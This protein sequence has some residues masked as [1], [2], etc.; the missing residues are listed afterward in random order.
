MAGGMKRNQNPHL[1]ARAAHEHSEGANL[2]LLFAAEAGQT[3][4]HQGTFTEPE[5][6]QTMV[7]RPQEVTCYRATKR[8]KFYSW[9]SQ[10]KMGHVTRFGKA[11]ASN[12][13]A[14]TCLAALETQRADSKHLTD[15][16]LLP[17]NPCLSIYWS[18]PE[19]ISWVM[20]LEAHPVCSL[21]SMLGGLMASKN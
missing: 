5:S 12:H 13:L 6:R 14:S 3:Q 1:L 16:D 8:G 2:Y 10:R 15:T 4:K 18:H 19:L 11:F 21:G 9:P 17:S 7:S 20:G